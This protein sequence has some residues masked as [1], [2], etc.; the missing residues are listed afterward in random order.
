MA[1][2]AKNMGMALTYEDYLEFPNDGRRYEILEGDLLITPA[3][4]RACFASDEPGIY[5][6]AWYSIQEERPWRE[7]R[8]SRSRN[9]SLRLTQSRRFLPTGGAVGCR[10]IIPGQ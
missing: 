1:D 5:K 6:A 7:R 10:F 3:P 4:A 9:E 2:P 8:R